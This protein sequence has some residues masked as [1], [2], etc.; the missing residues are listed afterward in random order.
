MRWILVCTGVLIL[1]ML[2]R[3]TVRSSPV[4]EEKMD[5]YHT[6]SEYMT[7][8]ASQNPAQH[9]PQVRLSKRTVLEFKRIIRAMGDHRL[10]IPRLLC[11]NKTFLQD[12]MFSVIRAQRALPR[13]PRKLHCISRA[14]AFAEAFLTFTNFFF[15]QTEFTAALAAWQKIRPFNE[16]ELEAIPLIMRIILLKDACLLVRKHQKAPDTPDWEE[17]L[18]HILHALKY[19]KR[20]CL[21]HILEE[22]SLIHRLLKQDL[23]YRQMDAASRKYYRKTVSSIAKQTRTTEEAVCKNALSLCQKAPSGSAAAHVGYYLLDEGYQDLLKRLHC[24]SV[25]RR[26]GIFCYQHRL[27]FFQIVSWSFFFFMLVWGYR[28]RMPVLLLIPFAFFFS[29]TAQYAFLQLGSAGE[30]TVPSLDIQRLCKTQQILV[31]MPAVLTSA[32]QALSTVKQM[33]VAYQANRD[34]HL[35]FLLIGDFQDSLTAVLSADHEIISAAASAVSALSA[36]QQHTFLYL[37]R[38][39]IYTPGESVYQCREKK[40]GAIEAVLRMICGRSV[41][42]QFEFASFDPAVLTNQY[43]LVIVMNPDTRLPPGSVYQMAG[44]MLHPLQ[45]RCLWK[46][47]MRGVSILQPRMSTASCFLKTGF[48]HFAVQ[49][50][51]QNGLDD[52]DRL[53]IS[54]GTFEGSAVI[55]PEPFLDEALTHIPEGKLLSP[56]LLEGMLAGCAAADDIHLYHRVPATLNA[57]GQKLHQ[58]TRSIWQLLPWLIPYIG[59]DRQNK[60]NGADRFKIRYAILSTLIAPVQLLLLIC[61]AAAG[62]ELL[63]AAVTLIPGLFLFFRRP[64]EGCAHFFSRLALLPCEAWIR[65]DAVFRTLYRMLFSHQKQLEDQ[66]AVQLSSVH[67]AKNMLF[68]TLNMSFAGL[69]AALA[70]LLNGAYWGLIPALAWAAFPFL[71]PALEQER[72]AFEQ[73]NAY[74]HEVL[75]KLAQKTWLFFDTIVTE[76]DHFLPSETVEITSGNGLSH[77]TTPLAAGFYLCALISGEKLG[78]LSSQEMCSRIDETVQTLEKMTRWHGLFY[79][80][81]DTQTLTP[82]FPAMVS[83]SDCGLL[84]V[85]LLT[86]AQGIRT[87]LAKQALNIY[88][89]SERL[90]RLAWDM[91]L[92]RLY[93]HQ[94]NSFFKEVDPL[95][96]ADP[97]SVS[98][99][100]E[101][102]LLSYV[103]LMLERV[104]LSHA[105]QLEHFRDR[106][107]TDDLFPFLFLPPPPSTSLSR[108]SKRLRTTVHHW[109]Y[110]KIHES[111][112][113]ILFP[114]ASML[115]LPMDLKRN[116]RQLRRLQNL[117]LEGP[118]GLFESAELIKG[119]KKVK[120]NRSYSAVHQGIILCSICNALSDGYLCDLFSNTPR[121]KAYRLLLAKPL[122]RT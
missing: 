63:T 120:I 64:P 18:E 102:L 49:D 122:Q 26:F 20:A 67:S 79:E 97:S 75:M 54:S 104:P 31:V 27:R 77:T 115:S 1:F 98:H 40:R 57:W 51:Q 59:Y 69:F 55:D 110:S 117:G 60:L 119:R 24:F 103:A 8:A 14:A 118:L 48:S 21:N 83:S 116:F 9:A 85:C 112:S 109:R 2:R 7:A 5:T 6:L 78:L 93:D 100:N 47:H 45:K 106:A 17:R 88:G 107:K 52:I 73:S 90:D 62:R 84:A 94:A 15:T 68:F 101:S 42:D 96:D 91:E 41:H 43:R 66:P 46:G 29:H 3:K 56:A 121:A 16:K 76:K 71:L 89:L 61:S 114:Y 28:I 34:K 105:N 11:E 72:S 81:Y 53:F 70:F 99:A 58:N 39:R 50:E 44:A 33:A 95:T 13:L 35:H 82:V 30:R 86:S 4:P 65:M 74:M 37:Q 32:K 38:K 25:I 19:L 22:K 111:K 113:D 36:D 87:L 10:F 80:R 92:N 23:I 12:E 108:T